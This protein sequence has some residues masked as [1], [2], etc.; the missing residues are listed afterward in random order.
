MAQPEFL[1][2]QKAE[3]GK[4]GQEVTLFPGQS[5]WVHRPGAVAKHTVKTIS[6]D[7]EDLIKPEDSKAFVDRLVKAAA[8]RATSPE[9]KAQREKDEAVPIE[10]PISVAESSVRANA[11]CKVCGNP[12]EVILHPKTNQ[13]VWVHKGGPVHSRPI[14]V[15]KTTIRTP[16]KTDEEKALI[17]GG[18]VGKPTGNP[19]TG[20]VTL[21]GRPARGTWDPETGTVVQK[22]AP[23]EAEVVDSDPDYIDANGKL[24]SKRDAT[25]SKASR[26]DRGVILRGEKHLE[27]DHP[28]IAEDSLHPG[29]QNIE[30]VV[31]PTTGRILRKNLDQVPKGNLFETSGTSTEAELTEIPVRATTWKTGGSALNKQGKIAADTMVKK[32]LQGYV[33]LARWHKE[34]FDPNNKYEYQVYTQKADDVVGSSPMI[35][36]RRRVKY[37]N[38][39]APVLLQDG[40]IPHANTDPA[41]PRVQNPGQSFIR[42]EPKELPEGTAP[43]T[44]TLPSGKVSVGRHPNVVGTHLIRAVQGAMK[45]EIAET[46]NAKLD[47]FNLGS[48]EAR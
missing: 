9:A 6:Y 40:S 23:R 42:P 32:R 37:C 46:G 26:A 4:C 15:A 14:V 18:K 44:R 38:K 10:E 24:T 34:K 27:E 35:G 21:P 39:C 31:H 45:Q 43:W 5:G 29:K 7:D 36:V 17:K 41:A 22:V 1:P 33:D 48:G 11:N 3:C 2:G 8:A 19:V 20:E 13:R 28:W 12:I 47:G 25:L 30:T 16:V